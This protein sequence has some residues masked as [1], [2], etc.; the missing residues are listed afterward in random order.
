[1]RCRELR[2][3][4]AVLVVA[5]GDEREHVRRSVRVARREAPISR[6]GNRGASVRDNCLNGSGDSVA[7]VRRSVIAP[8]ERPNGATITRSFGRRTA[9]S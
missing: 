1:M 2:L 6:V 4:L 7:I 9:N 5:N 3:R 8:T